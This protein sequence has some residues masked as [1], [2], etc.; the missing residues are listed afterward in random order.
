VCGSSNITQQQ[1]VDLR[2]ILTCQTATATT[3]EL[4]A[5]AA[6]GKQNQKI[7]KKEE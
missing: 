1:Q 2:Q 5:A 3:H 4:N 6:K 7:K